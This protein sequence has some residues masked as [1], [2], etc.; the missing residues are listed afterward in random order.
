MQ[1]MIFSRPDAA[2]I[3]SSGVGCHEVRQVEAED[4]ASDPATGC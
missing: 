4:S 2:L 3:A 1:R